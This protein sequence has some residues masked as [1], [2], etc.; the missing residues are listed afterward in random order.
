MS[1][2]WSWGKNSSGKNKNVDDY[3]DY[4]Y[5]YS[6]RGSTTRRTS[7]SDWNWGTWGTTNTVEDDDEDIFIKS[8]PNYF[9]PSQQD[10]SWKIAD[11]KD[12]TARNRNTIREFARYFYHRMID[13]KD[14][15]KEKYG[16]PESL[17]EH[18]IAALEQKKQQYESLWD[19]FIPGYTPL[20]QAIALFNEL[21][22]Q[23]EKDGKGMKE[24]TDE[25]MSERIV[26]MDFHED[27]FKDP[28]FNELLEMQELS[29]TNKIEV[30]NMISMIENLGSQFKIEKEITEKRAQNSRLVSKKI[31]RDYSELHMIDLYQRLM[32]TFNT[33]LLTKDLII[34]TPIQKTEHKQKIIII[35]DYSGSM[36]MP[37]KQKW[38]LALMIDRL[39]YVMKEEAEVFFSFFVN[40]PNQLKF[41]HLYNRE[42]VL[43]FWAQFSTRPNGGD[44]DIGA[45]IGKIKEQIEDK[46]R[47]CNLGID[48]SQEK[49][50]ILIINDGQDCIKT[51]GF[52]YKT[53][54][55]TVVDHEN[56]ELKN[57]CLQNDG[58]YVYANNSQVVTYD[59]GGKLIMK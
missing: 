43:K 28:I 40:N 4:D 21:K 49:P 39:K 17:D 15:F 3:D 32:P 31:M 5:G 19:K 35:I 25:K 12:D 47:L 56:E 7:Y 54:A 38:V 23:A 34:N 57:L 14:Y 6:R 2:Y 18:E 42:S 45:M 1:K 13:E 51:T 58:K 59:K 48:L 46:H 33:K 10:I 20:E 29:R 36:S 27:V 30:L 11:Y 53:N 26:G 37:E 41:F 50:E 52:V 8:H 9:T 55:I 24:M 16:T 44:T 22:R